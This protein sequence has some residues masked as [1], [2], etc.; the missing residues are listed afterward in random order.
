MIAAD[1]ETDPFKAGRV[2]KPFV[3]GWTDG[4]SFTYAWGPDCVNAFVD[5]VAPLGE[6]V[7]MHNGGKFDFH[8]FYKRASKIKMIRNRIAKMKIGETWFIDS[9]LLIPVALAASG[10]KDTDF[11]YD[12][13]EAHR[14][15]EHRDSIVEYLRRDCF[16]LHGWVNKFNSLFGSNSLT[17]PSAA[18]E[19]L[20]QIGY[21]IP[22][23]TEA[24]DAS[25]RPYYLGGYVGA[26]RGHYQNMQYVDINS[27]YPNVMQW[28]HPWGNECETS[29]IPN[30]DCYFATITA[31]ANGR[32]P[33]RQG[34]R[35]T[36]P[37][38]GSLQWY[39]LTHWEIDA[40]TDLGWLDDFDFRQC[41][42]FYETVSF[43][44]F[45]DKFYAMKVEAELAGD[46][47]TR[48]FAKLI[49]N[50][51][52]GRF[53]LN[54]RKFTKL[55]ITELGQWPEGDEWQLLED[56]EALTSIWEAPDPQNK[57]VNVA[58]AASITGAARSE[59]MRALYQCINPV[60]WDTD[61]I[62]AQDT[63]ALS[64]GH[65]IGEWSLEGT[66][67]DV[68]IVRPKLY[69]GVTHAGTVKSAHKGVRLDLDA[70]RRIYMGEPVTWHS[71][72][73][74]FAV[75]ASPAFQERTLH[76]PVDRLAQI[77]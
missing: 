52:Y 61:S 17:A 74:S 70:I 45:V 66:F 64:F 37:D 43:G 40:A 41:V 68:W 72:A 23:M 25:I 39:R 7:Y 48:L 35:L 5:R 30:S 50:S 28:Q 55:Q 33:V 13:L 53:G 65:G 18:M 75:G 62:I 76:Y 54:P 63:S 16:A 77:A 9:F 11:D 19:Q 69:G 32:L 57:F 4:A 31:K 2:P 71:D 47:D 14:R 12:T 36:Y 58:T 8:F 3:A 34:A 44:E 56:T 15:N 10:V 51:L 29:I 60:Y 20:R 42:N 49:M 38:D 46:A 27:S 67:R 22:R 24:T 1:L 6:T 73:P 26:R 21:R 59:L